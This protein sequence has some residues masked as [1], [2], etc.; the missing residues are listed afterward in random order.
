MTYRPRT[1]PPA[2]DHAFLA[3]VQ[4]WAEAPQSF[5]EQHLPEYRE[6]L[7]AVYA[8][9]AGWERARIEPLWPL[10]EQASAAFET[11][12]LI[13]LRAALGELERRTTPAPPSAGVPGGLL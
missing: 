11:E 4:A 5:R 8:A 1:P 7:L 9:V 10:V 3:K 13:S 12:N 6:R 2:P